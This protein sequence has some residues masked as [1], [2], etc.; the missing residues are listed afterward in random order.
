LHS[1]PEIENARIDLY[2]DDVLPN[3]DTRDSQLI[4]GA[5]PWRGSRTEDPLL[6]QMLIEA[7]TEVGDIV[8]HYCYK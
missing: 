6:L 5:L 1:I 7:G 8:V 2:E 3:F 4:N